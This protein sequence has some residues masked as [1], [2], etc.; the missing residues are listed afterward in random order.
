MTGTQPGATQLCTEQSPRS[1]RCPGPEC[2][3]SFEQAQSGSPPPRAAR[4][5]RLQSVPAV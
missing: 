4:R 1:V 5:D 3:A 2:S